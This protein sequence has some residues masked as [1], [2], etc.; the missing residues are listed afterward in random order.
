M[1]QNGF[2]L[3]LCIL[4]LCLG[5]ADRVSATVGERSWIDAEFTACNRASAYRIEPWGESSLQ[6]FLG[7]SPKI[8]LRLQNS[9]SRV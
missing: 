8:N 6:R 2:F 4:G 7:C 9:S 1:R 3:M 5:C